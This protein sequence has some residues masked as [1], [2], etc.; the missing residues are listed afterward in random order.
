VRFSHRRTSKI[1]H[2]PTPTATGP[3]WE[4]AIRYDCCGGA[5]RISK[6]LS[7]LRRNKSHESKLR[8]EIQGLARRCATRKCGG[9]AASN[10]R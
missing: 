4:R 1:K 8:A 5:R 9:I 7:S 3:L 6:N 10:A 2:G